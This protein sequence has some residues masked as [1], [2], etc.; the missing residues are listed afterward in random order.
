MLVAMK[1]NEE[2]A[3]RAKKIAAYLKKAYPKPKSELSHEAPFQFLA[4]VIMSAQ[5]TDKAVNKLTATLWKKYKTPE[6][7]ASAN[8]AMFTKELSSI[9]FF[10]NKAKA[11]IGAAKI[12]VK[13]QG[14]R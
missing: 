5:C 8:L 6:D 1:K 13:E 7:F 12:L 4:S 3:R 2:R 9:P 10:R 11:I 14:G